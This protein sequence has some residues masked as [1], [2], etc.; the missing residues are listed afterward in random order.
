MTIP[1]DVT[2]FF[3]GSL[4]SYGAA[5]LP[6]GLALNSSTGLITGNPTTPGVSSVTVT[7]TNPSGSAQQSFQWT[8]SA[9][10]SVPSQVTGLTATPGDGQVALSWSAPSDGGSPITDYVIE[11]STGGGFTTISDGTSTATSFNHTSLTNGTEYTYRVS[12]VNSV[13]QGTASATASATPAASSGVSIAQRD[14][15]ID[16]GSAFSYTF[17][18]L[19]IGTGD[20]IVSV[21]HRAGDTATA[22]TLG[23]AAMSQV[24]SASDGTQGISVWRLDAQSAGTADVAVTLA[25]QAQRCCVAVWTVAGAGAAAASFDIAPVNDVNTASVSATSGGVIL[26][27][28]YAVN[29]A[30]ALP[31]MTFTNATP[32]DLGGGVFVEELA[33]DENV[34]HGLADRATSAT[35]SETVTVTH[36]S[37]GNLQMLALVAVAPS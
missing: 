25:I 2:P 20:V 24:G 27:H 15:G 32:V 13:G 12:A 23:G 10:A 14:T 6:A 37:T 21:A 1:L 16:G 29:S 34:F 31:S 9:G 4:L 19:N 7:A 18:G 28:S 5:G 33:V 35:Q 30:V 11:F 36:P 8:I 22:V 17:P 26:A 3:S